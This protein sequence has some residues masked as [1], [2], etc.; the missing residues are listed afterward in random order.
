MTL[1]V[2]SLRFDHRAWNVVYPAFTSPLNIS[3]AKTEEWIIYLSLDIKYI[4]IVT[5]L[6]I[7]TNYETLEIIFK[8]LF[9]TT[10][11]HFGFFFF[12][13]LKSR[14]I[15]VLKLKKK[16]NMP[17]LTLWLW[18]Y[19]SYFIITMIIFVFSYWPLTITPNVGE[20]AFIVNNVYAC[21]PSDPPFSY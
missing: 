18:K 19:V 17:E 5:F 1:I 10:R 8:Y 4:F 20:V 16:K 6:V 13:K 15:N 3:R 7:Y 12:W 14:L 2:R 9:R 21:R 11:V